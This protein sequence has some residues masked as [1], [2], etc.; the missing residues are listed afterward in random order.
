MPRE[1]FMAK[2]EVTDG[3]WLW[4][5]VTRLNRAK[6]AYGRFSMYLDGRRTYYTAHRMSYELFVGPIPEGHEIHH[7]CD[8]PLCVN[9]AHLLAMT[10]EE[11]RALHRPDVCK[12]GHTLSGENLYV[13]SRG[14][15]QCRECNRR[16]SREHARRRRAAR[17]TGPDRSD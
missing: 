8:V 7:K 15:H 5:G 1:K 4:R 14:W 13:T 6:V 3:C 10:P 11:H 17:L 2:V 9:P 16:W 12:Y